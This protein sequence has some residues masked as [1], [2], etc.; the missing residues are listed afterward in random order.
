MPVTDR[1]KLDVKSA[2]GSSAPGRCHRG[3]CPGRRAPAVNPNGVWTERDTAPS[4]GFF[5]SSR[6][7]CLGSSTGMTMPMGSPRRMVVGLWS[8][9]RKF[10]VNAS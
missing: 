3:L 9:N 1:E 6:A 5:S 10:A 4:Y 8:C 2:A 7:N